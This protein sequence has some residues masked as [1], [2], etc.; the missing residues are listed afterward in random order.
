MHICVCI[1]VCRYDPL[2][3]CLRRPAIDIRYLSF[4]LCHIFETRSVS[5]SGNHAFDY[6]GWPV[7]S[8][9]V[10]ISA[11]SSG[12]THAGNTYPGFVWV[13]DTQTGV[14]I[15]VQLPT[16]TSLQTLRYLNFL[17]HFFMFLSF[18]FYVYNS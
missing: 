17:Q 5:V 12:V 11:T 2:C 10:L 13:L 18:N 9:V 7:A 15:L 14:C 16:Q 1:C 3:Q 4:T 6:S 8:R